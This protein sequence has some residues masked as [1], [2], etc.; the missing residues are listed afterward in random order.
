MTYLAC[1]S[2]NRR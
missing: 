1:C 2:I